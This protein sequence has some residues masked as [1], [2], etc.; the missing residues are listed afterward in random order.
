M[1][2]KMSFV[3]WGLTYFAS[4]QIHAAVITY[5]KCFVKR[6][7]LRYQEMGKCTNKRSS[8]EE[9]KSRRM[10]KNND[11]IEQRILVFVAS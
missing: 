1:I 8:F 4:R 6:V 11:E 9:K 7:N 10:S 3:I 2:N 5:G